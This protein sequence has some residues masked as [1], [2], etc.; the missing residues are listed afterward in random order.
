MVCHCKGR[1]WL[2]IARAEW[3]SAP[4]LNMLICMTSACKPMILCYFMHAQCMQATF[5]CML[6][7]L[8]EL[9]QM[10]VID[11]MCQLCLRVLLWQGCAN[12]LLYVK[13]KLYR[14][15]NAVVG[16]IKR[17]SHTCMCCMYGTHTHMYTYIYIYI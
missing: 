5:V 16:S 11:H 17:N 13:F 15:T 1:W 14:S 9:W 4:H 6:L 3:C 10:K 12:A 8:V 7:C 2:N